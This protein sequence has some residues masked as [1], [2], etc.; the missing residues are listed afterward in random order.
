VIKDPRVVD[1][2]NQAFLDMM[3]RYYEQA[4]V[5]V[6]NGELLAEAHPEI[7]FNVGVAPGYQEKSRDH[8]DRMRQFSPENAPQSPCPPQYD[9]KWRYMWRVGEFADEPGKQEILNVCPEGFGEWEG[10]MNRWGSQLL[11]GILTIVNMFEKAT[12]LDPNF[13]AE[14]MHKGAHLLGPTGSNLAEL[15]LGTILAA[16]H[17]DLCFLTVHGKSRFPGLSIWLRNGTKQGVTVPEGH[18]LFQAGKMFEYLTGGYVLAGFHEVVH[19]EKTAQAVERARAAGKSLWRVSSTMFGHLRSNLSLEPM[20]E[21][22]ALYPQ[23]AEETREKYPPM[24]VGEFVVN[25]LKVIS[26]WQGEAPS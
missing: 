1:A 6:A 5:K 2:D 19:T 26:L 3:E 9:A 10:T 4:G 7:G 15:G 20:P 8:C 25:E 16:F 24:N 22:E 13:L 12:G 21:L 11:R 23:S 14:R 17:Y 18:L